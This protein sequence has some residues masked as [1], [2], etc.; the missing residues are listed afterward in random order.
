MFSR[1]GE[2]RLVVCK[3]TIGS[4][5]LEN[6]KNLNT[7]KHDRDRHGLGHIIVEETVKRLGGMISYSESCGMF[8][9]QIVLPMNGT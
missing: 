8:I 6:N 9:V 1:H 2:N 5:V 7:S 4:S 3:N